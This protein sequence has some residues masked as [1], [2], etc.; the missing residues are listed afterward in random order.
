MRSVDRELVKSQLEGAETFNPFKTVTVIV[1][2]PSFLHY[3]RQNP[4]SFLVSSN[5]MPTVDT[6]FRTQNSLR[7]TPPPLHSRYAHGSLK[8][9]CHPV[10]GLHTRHPPMR[11]HTILLLLLL[12]NHILRLL[13]ST[14][15]GGLAELFAA[16]GGC[17][18]L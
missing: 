2:R 15:Y 10:Y 5:K 17:A 9:S 6:F 7:Q 4:P 18:A 8:V 11:P 13:L 1:K 3:R 14:R 16:I 12:L